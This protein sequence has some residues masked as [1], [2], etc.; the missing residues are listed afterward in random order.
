[1][2]KRF[3]SLLVVLI[4]GLLMVACGQGS[5][6]SQQG[7]KLKVVATTTIVGDVVAQ[8][9][10]DLIEL[11]VLLPVGTDPHS[12]DLTPQDDLTMTLYQR[13]RS[14]FFNRFQCIHRF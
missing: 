14:K 4:A 10:G 5:E 3:Y 11:D 1:M 6:Q 12:F 8:V 9:G 2:K 7:D 13:I